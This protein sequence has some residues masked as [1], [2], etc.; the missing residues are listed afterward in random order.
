LNYLPENIVKRW[1]EIEIKTEHSFN[2]KK[3][4]SL[5]VVMKKATRSMR[6]RYLL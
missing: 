3:P 1:N 4:P 5:K 6:M 2:H